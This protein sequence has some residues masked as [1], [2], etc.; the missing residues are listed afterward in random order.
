MVGSSFKGTAA[1]LQKM[2][3]AWCSEVVVNRKEVFM[4]K[5][6]RYPGTSYVV[7]ALKGLMMHPGMFR[8]PIKVYPLISPPSCCLISASVQLLQHTGHRQLIS[9]PKAV[10]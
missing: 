2:A 5:H 8:S 3:G 6:L 7:V 10:V 4:Y 9:S 1:W